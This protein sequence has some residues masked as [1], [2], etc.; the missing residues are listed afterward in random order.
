MSDAAHS[1]P[2]SQ[3]QHASQ[4]PSMHELEQCTLSK[5]GGLGTGMQVHMPS[6]QPSGLQYGSSRVHSL[7]VS[8][9]IG[10]PV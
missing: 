4:S 6:A 9:H 10:A 1:A 8:M 7:A 5:M 2:Q 3:P